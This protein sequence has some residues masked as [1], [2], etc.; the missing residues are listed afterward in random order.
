MKKEK[1]KM[2]TLMIVPHST[3][4]P[5]S[6][7]LS[8]GFVIALSIIF[9][10]IVVWAGL[11]IHKQID[12]WAMSSENKVLVKETEYFT[13]EII[14]TRQMADNLKEIE[15]ELKKLLGLKDKKKII[16]SGGPSVSDLENVT[17]YLQEKKLTITVSEFNKHFSAL[18]T[19]TN[20]LKESF[21]E[22]NKFIQS[23]RSRWASTPSVV[24]CYGP[25]SCPFGPRVHPIK[26]NR[27][28]HLAIDIEADRGTP[29]K[30][31]A[32][33]EVILADWQPGYGKLVVID[34]GWGFMTRYGHCSS[35]IVKRGQKVKK[36]QVIAY[37]G[38]TGYATAP[39][40]HYEIWKNGIAQ[41]PAKYLTEAILK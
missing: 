2:F 15:R 1:S 9:T 38:S 12:Y 8:K 41:N 30:T 7:D 20:E 18:K 35:I 28:I 40:L 27:E 17:K 31:T 34:H 16:Q 25:I 13:Q 4:R 11:I 14:K 10:G 32:N 6:L 3:R 37:V 5:I 21:A 29:I 39:H 22:T 36:N 24:P 23:E 26:G 33:G 19:E